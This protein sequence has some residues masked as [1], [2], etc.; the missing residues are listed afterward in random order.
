MKLVCDSGLLSS[1]RSN[2]MA[3]R[4]SARYINHNLMRKTSSKFIIGIEV[5]FLNLLRS[6]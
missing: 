6:D 3:L 1:C 4:M 5:S 2:K